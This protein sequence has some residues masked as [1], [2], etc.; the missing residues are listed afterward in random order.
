MRRPSV[1][2][3][4][5]QL[6]VVAFMVEQ[7]CLFVFMAT[8]TTHLHFSPVGFHLKKDKMRR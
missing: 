2:G 7:M 4:L 5:A 8:L 3:V 1:P 6:I